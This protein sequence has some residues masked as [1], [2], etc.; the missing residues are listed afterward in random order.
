MGKRC[1]KFKTLYFS[2]VF[3]FHKI[4]HLL[5]RQIVLP[6]GLKIKTYITKQLP[7]QII[8]LKK[9]KKK[10]IL[11]YVLEI[12]IKILNEIF[13]KSIQQYR[14]R[15]IM[16]EKDKLHKIIPLNNNLSRNKVKYH[17]LNHHLNL[18]N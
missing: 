2:K 17:R 13:P 14:Q 11:K 6:F 9:N 3:Q 7:T 1:L 10:V 16:A 8:N 12:V 18:S 15:L 5:I 4:W